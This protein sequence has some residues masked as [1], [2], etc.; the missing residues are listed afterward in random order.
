MPKIYGQFASSIKF[1]LC[2]FGPAGQDP[3]M[4][5]LNLIFGNSSKKIVM[6]SRRLNSVSTWPVSGQVNQCPLP[7][8]IG[9]HQKQLQDTEILLLINTINLHYNSSL[10]Q[11][12]V[13]N[14]RSKVSITADEFGAIV[15]WPCIPLPE[16]RIRAP[17]SINRLY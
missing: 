7:F 10:V 11:N 5:C 13:I 2:C 14:S 6:F 15:N 9:L 16:K 12:V 4:H 1:F 17:N 3:Y 8:I